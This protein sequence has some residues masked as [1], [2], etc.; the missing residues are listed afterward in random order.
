MSRPEKNNFTSQKFK[1]VYICFVTKVKVIISS[2]V[3]N[4]V[5][6]PTI[7]T[8]TVQLVYVSI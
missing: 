8:S 6:H 1:F 5:E 2:Q 3:T 7:Q 4:T